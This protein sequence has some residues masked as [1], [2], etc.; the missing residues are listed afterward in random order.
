[1]TLNATE[2]LLP[3]EVVRTRLAQYLGPFTSKNAVQM[4]AK[5]ALS[6][7]ADRVTRTQVPALIDALGPTLRTLL[8]KASA[9]RVAEEIRKELGLA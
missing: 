4:I 6:T 3:A 1:M 8:G 7:D 9:E 2:T 5:Q